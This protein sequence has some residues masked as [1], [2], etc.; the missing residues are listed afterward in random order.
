MENSEATQDQVD[1]A[2]DRLANAMHMLEF[3]Q[4]NKTD[5]SNLATQI[6]RLNQADYSEASWK[7]MM[8][9]LNE[10][11]NVLGNDNA[12]QEEVDEAYTKLIKAFLELRLKPNK[13]LLQDLINQANQ[14]KA[15]SYTAKSWGIMQDALEEANKVL[16]NPEADYATVQKAIESLKGSIE[17]LEEKVETPV[18]PGDS[19]G[20][21]N[22]I[23]TG[24]SNI[25]SQLGA[26][27]LLTGAAIAVLRRK[28]VEE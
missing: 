26:V 24:D 27:M 17:G 13:D 8:P 28:K 11:K 18:A 1:T 5:L 6:E 2:F 9:V 19:G 10:A 15:A 22:A 12:M 14:L 20:K 23:K 3:Y 16:A 7:A 4:G 25:M 21:G